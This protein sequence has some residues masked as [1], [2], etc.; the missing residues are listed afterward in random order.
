MQ[1]FTPTES[2]PTDFSYVEGILY[3]NEKTSINSNTQ[4][5]KDYIKILSSENTYT[6]IYAPSI[7]TDKYLGKNVVVAYDNEN[8]LKNINETENTSVFINTPTDIQ[9]EGKYASVIIPDDEGSVLNGILSVYD[10]EFDVTNTEYKLDN[11]TIIYNNT[12]LV[13]WKGDIYTFKKKLTN[14]YKL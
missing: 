8:V 1:E 10:D 5:Q 9:L 6:T 11:A 3:A 14:I 12:Y 7:D 2:F 13:N 4:M